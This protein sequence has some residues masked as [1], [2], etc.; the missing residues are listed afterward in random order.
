MM[1]KIHFILIS[2]SIFSA[3]GSTPD[4]VL[5]EDLPIALFTSPTPTAETSAFPSATPDSVL[6]P[7]PEQTPI[8]VEP[9]AGLPVQNVTVSIS[10]VSEGSFRNGFHKVSGQASLIET[11]GQKFLRVE[12]FATENGPDLFFYLI[13]N[14][15]GQPQGGDF[16]NLGRLK[17]TQGSANYE[18]PADINLADYQSVSVWCKVFSVNFGS[19][20]LTAQ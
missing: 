1:F 15:S 12:N 8:D 3:C 10:T 2:L 5:N 20:K 17:A 4:V 16:I 6:T 18:I 13:R 7:A 9:P 11:D 14:D 19:A